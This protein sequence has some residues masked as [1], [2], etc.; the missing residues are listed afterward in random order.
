LVFHDE[1]VDDFVR[2]FLVE[3]RAGGFDA[4]L[5]YRKA[6]RKEL[7]RYTK[8]TPPH[9]RAARKQRQP[10]ARIIEYVMTANGPEPAGEETA[11]PDYEHYIEHQIKPVA[12][13]VM[14]FLGKDFDTVVDARRQLS[15]F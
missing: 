7:E 15:L 4:E 3:L 2:A 5:V 12:E 14:R 8:T 9:V 13:A 10:G 6:V 1:P 11:R